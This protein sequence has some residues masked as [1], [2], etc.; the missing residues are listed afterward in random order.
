MRTVTLSLLVLLCGVAHAAD[1][2]AIRIASGESGGTYQRI[3]AKNFERELRDYDVFHRPTTGT[4]ANLEM[5]VSGEADVAFAQADIYAAQLRQDP[6]SLESLVVIGQIA[7]EC[8][9]IA[10]RKG[11][12]VESLAQLGQP[13]DG[14]P[15]K[16]AVGP[17]LGGSSGT[18]RH[19][20]ILDPSLANANVDHGGDILALNQLAVGAFDA[21][22]WVTDPNNLGHKLLQ[23]LRENEKLGLMPIDDPRFDYTLPNG[24]KVYELREVALEDGWRPDTLETVCTGALVLARRDG[25]PKFIQKL[26][27]IVSK[28]PR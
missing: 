6:A 17:A 3:Y 24:T 14:R 7:K 11:G 8:V 4:G 9:Y 25:D 27:E 16:I 28:Y 26:A 1:K 10:Y 22:I 21:M 23:A 19:F 15:A 2:P 12:S 18:W 20:T 13:V 5:L